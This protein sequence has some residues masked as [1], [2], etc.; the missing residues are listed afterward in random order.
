MEAELFICSEYIT[1]ALFLKWS[2]VLFLINR[3]FIIIYLF[4]YHSTYIQYIPATLEDIVL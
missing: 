4:V 2:T 1:V 3:R